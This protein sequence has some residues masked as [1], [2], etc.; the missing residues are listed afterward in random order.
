MQILLQTRK[1]SNAAGAFGSVERWFG[2]LARRKRLCILL[3]GL[4]VIIVRVALM[5][6][7]GLP[8]PGAHDEFSYLLAADTF[9]HG[10]LT[11]PTHPM[12]IHFESFHI[13]E[14]PTY[15]SMY[16]P[17]QGF[18][19]AVGELLGHPWIGQVLVTGLMCGAMCWMMQGW[20]PP[21]WALLGTALVILQLGILSY[22]MNSYWSGSVVALGGALVLGA[23]PRLRRRPRMAVSLL[24]ALGLLILANSRPYESLIFSIPFAVALLWRLFHSSRTECSALL[25]YA[26][27]PIC[28]ALLCV[29][30]AMAYYNYR[31][32][33]NP[34]R[35][36][37]EVNSVTYAAPPYF[38]WQKPLP[39]VVYHHAVMRDFYRLM[40]ER[41]ERAHTLH[42]YLR[43]CLGKFVYC[44]WFYLQLV[45]ALPLIALPWA[46]RREK[47]LLPAVSCAVVV[48][49]L[50]IETWTLPHYFAP[51]AGALYILVVQCMREL[52]HWSPGGRAIGRAI[53]RPI[54][55]LVCAVICLR[56]IAVASHSP[57]E[58]GWPRGNQKRAAILRQL[59]KKPD[60][61]LVIVR[62]APDHDPNREWVYNRANIDQAK[63]VWARDMG[64]V[65]NRE[66]L[67]YFAAR[68][69]WLVEADSAKPHLVPYAP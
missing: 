6:V 30:F 54:P 46:V 19:L 58:A 41:F 22:W 15:M 34:W 13:I 1:S 42:G 39:E 4:T 52:W 27:V 56:V 32:T 67:G 53:V 3:A 55:L 21:G 51:A 60:G 14:Q 5:P 65:N 2:R 61:Q 20:L 11:N 24:M 37:Y 43:L 38:L 44:W 18:V 23:W 59:E 29:A 9:A 12:R 68:K 40:L 7:L 31:I 49:A 64:T 10:R 17:A 69:V 36:P 16:P 28:A 57:I 47:M 35:M 26:F 50:A 33:G 25:H 8:E 63:V 48:V 45:L 62:Y 66:L